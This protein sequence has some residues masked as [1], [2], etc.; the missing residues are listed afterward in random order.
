MA[1]GGHCEPI[2]IL[3]DSLL[4]K[5]A[6]KNERKK[7]ISEIINNAM[8]HFIFIRT[9]KVW[10]PWNDASRQISRH[11]WIIVAVIIKIE[12]KIILI[13]L[14]CIKSSIPVIKVN[15]AIEPIKGH[16]LLST[17]WKGWN[18]ISLIHLNREMKG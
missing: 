5:K 9:F 10:L 14:K 13:L 8:P 15:A 2:S 16:G 12:I 18:F 4:W 1:V 3:G 6:Q 17:I 11:H 7:K